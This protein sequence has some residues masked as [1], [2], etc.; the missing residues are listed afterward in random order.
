VVGTC[1]YHVAT[2]TYIILTA[3]ILTTID[4]PLNL[5]IMCLADYEPR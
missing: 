5:Y 2:Y 3:H 1:L 4:I